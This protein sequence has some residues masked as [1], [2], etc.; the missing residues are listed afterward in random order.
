[1]NIYE[2]LGRALLERCDGFVDLPLDRAVDIT[3]PAGTDPVWVRW[4][5][6]SDD[7]TSGWFLV[8]GPLSVAGFR[9]RYVPP[10][11]A[12]EEDEDPP[13]PGVAISVLVLPGTKDADGK[14][15][16]R[17]VP[18]SKGV[19]LFFSQEEAQI[20]QWFAKVYH[21]VARA[22]ANTKAKAPPESSGS[23]AG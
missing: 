14:I 10:P 5:P 4:P 6:E 23:G 22:R 19:S 2:S 9:L 12:W 21:E 17:E 3:A 13:I 1:M 8:L 20:A 18:P 7:L 11:A 15:E 16:L